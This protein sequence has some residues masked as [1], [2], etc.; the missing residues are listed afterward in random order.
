MYYGLIL[1]LGLLI[2]SRRAPP[3][4]KFMGAGPAH[5]GILEKRLKN[6]IKKAHSSFPLPTSIR[7]PLMNTLLE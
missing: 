2:I 7:L 4:V 5:T 1:H 3:L 6:G